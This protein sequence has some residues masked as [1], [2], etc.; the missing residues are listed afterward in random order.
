MI[1]YLI[2]IT[3]EGG[4]LACPFKRE[5]EEKDIL[6]L[7]ENGTG[8]AKTRLFT[9]VFIFFNPANRAGKINEFATK[10]AESKEEIFGDIVLALKGKDVVKGFSPEMTQGIINLIR[11]NCNAQ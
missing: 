4:A 2:K 3:A 7:I 9:D 10:A 11:R 6:S 5:I 8:S 1:T